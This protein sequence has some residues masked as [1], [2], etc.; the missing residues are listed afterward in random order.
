MALVDQ[1]ELRAKYLN[2]AAHLL[3]VASPAAAAFLG[4]A[5]NRLVEDAG[6]EVPNRE[7]EAFRRSVCGACG[8]IMVPGWSC[9]VSS[10]TQRERFDIKD[11]S[12]TKVSTKPEKNTAY[13]CLR[14]HRETR[15]TLQTKPRRRIGKSR[16]L[17]DTKPAPGVTKS[18]KEADDITTKTA[19]VSSKQRQKARKGGLQAML[20]KKK[21]QTSG[22]GGFDLMDF[23]M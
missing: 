12:S 14:C 17:L 7:L 21:S 10:R 18:T 2:E 9:K 1:T 19:N 22:L 5:R 4:T 11:R 20:E 16:S 6:L 13:I 15:Q 23:A 3:A 8:S